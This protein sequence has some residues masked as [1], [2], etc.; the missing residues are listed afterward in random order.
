LPRD[1]NGRVPQEFD[2][3]TYVCDQWVGGFTQTGNF[4]AG[5]TEM[6]VTYPYLQGANLYSVI[7]IGP[8]GYRVAFDSETTT[9]VILL[10]K[11][12]WEAGVYTWRVAPYWTYSTSRYSWQQ[13][14]LLQTGGTFEKPYTGPER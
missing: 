14:C 12:P 3:S 5:D 9:A 6:T 11:L 10:D 7:V 8:D 4:M 13:V 1:P 2:L